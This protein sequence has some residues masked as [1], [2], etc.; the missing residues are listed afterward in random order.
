MV[1]LRGTVLH[2]VNMTGKSLVTISSA[3][4]RQAGVIYLDITD[5][6]GKK[7]HFVYKVL[8]I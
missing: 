8:R 1:D 5:V 4:V 2:R 7:Q 6:H 3:R